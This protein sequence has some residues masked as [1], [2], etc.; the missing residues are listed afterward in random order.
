MWTKTTWTIL[1]RYFYLHEYI[2]GKVSATGADYFIVLKPSI[3]LE[4]I[5][6]FL[7]RRTLFISPLIFFRHFLPSFFSCVILS[8]N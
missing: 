8:Y 2:R 4:F 6:I 1:S 7:L 5:Y 3:L